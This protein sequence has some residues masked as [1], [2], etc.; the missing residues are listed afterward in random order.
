MSFEFLQPET[1]PEALSLLGEHGDDAKV[2]AGGTAVVLMLHQQLIAPPVVLSLGRLPDLDYIR[3]EADHLHIGPLALL[4]DVERSVEVRKLVPLL[5]D[6]C[7]EVGN[8]RVRN[9]ATLGGNLAEA[10]YASDPPAALLALDARVRLE[11][12]HQSRVVRVADFFRGFYETALAADELIT[13][14]IVPLPAAGGRMSYTKYKSRSSEDRPCVGVA[15]LAQMQS[16]LVSRLAVA[17]GA[18][19]EV[20]SRIAAVEALA[21]GKRLTDELIKEIAAG[22]AENVETLDDMRGSAWYRTEMIRMHIARALK[23]IRNGHR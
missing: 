16:E 11:S 8:V 13:D 5:A 21:D 9:Q 3:L 2:L 22:Y 7:R 1:L 6:A 20:P 12:A 10:D 18:A 23:E 14:I 15:V 17:I 19:C 4:R